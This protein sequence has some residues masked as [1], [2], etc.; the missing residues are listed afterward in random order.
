MARRDKRVVAVAVA[1]LVLLLAGAGAWAVIRP[2]SYG[3]SRSGCV[4][5]MFPST[6]GGAL[7]HQC[8]ASART[9]CRNAFSHTDRF[10]L[11]ARP[12]C[13]EAGLAS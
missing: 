2:G 1:V 5:V 9:L 13:R 11:L 7:V 10:S 8:G 4:T 12:E 3:Q 6:T